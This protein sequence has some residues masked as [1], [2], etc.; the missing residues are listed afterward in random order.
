MFCSFYKETGSIVLFGKDF[1][2]EG[3]LDQFKESTGSRGFPWAKRTWK[4]VCNK[5]EPKTKYPE[6][7]MSGERVA[8][9]RGW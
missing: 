6:T 7:G 9:C 3:G 2:E 1:L 8:E 4:D 5:M